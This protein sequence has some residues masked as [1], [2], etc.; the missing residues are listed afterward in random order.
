[1][2]KTVKF[3]PRIVVMIQNLKDVYGSGEISNNKLRN[4][5]KME[6]KFRNHFKYCK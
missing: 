6:N 4:H 2:S 3:L 5:L 1:M